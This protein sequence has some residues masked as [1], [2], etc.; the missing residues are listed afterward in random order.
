M[1]QYL[2]PPGCQ[3]TAYKDICLPIFPLENETNLTGDEHIRF[4]ALSSLSLT[5][6]SMESLVS[7]VG[8]N[9]SVKQPMSSKWDITIIRSASNRFGVAVGEVMSTNDEIISIVNRVMSEFR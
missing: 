8:D 6:T 7:L 2:Q 4:I 3:H 9:L 1:F 5:K